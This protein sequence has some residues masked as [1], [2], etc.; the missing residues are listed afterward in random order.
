LLSPDVTR[1]ITTTRKIRWTADAELLRA[2]CV[3]GFIKK[4]KEITLK[5][6]HK[7]KNNIKPGL[8]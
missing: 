3:R 8:K 1:V 4:Q 5:P 7:W 2:N 6:S